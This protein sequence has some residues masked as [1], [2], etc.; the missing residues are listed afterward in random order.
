MTLCRQNGLE[1]ILNFRLNVLNVLTP[2]K[3][4]CL[5]IYDF[6]V[7]MHEVLQNKL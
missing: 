7:P 2:R 3:N 6:V 4:I 1:E 5:H